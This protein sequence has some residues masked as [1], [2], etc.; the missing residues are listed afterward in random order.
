MKTRSLSSLAVLAC[1]VV[2]FVGGCLMA[3]P[4]EVT[5]AV[6]AGTNNLTQATATEWQAVAAKIDE[7]VPEV[8]LTLSDAQ[9]QAIVEFVQLNEI[10]GVQ[11][12]QDTVEQAQNDPGSIVVPDGFLELFS[13]LSELGFNEF[14]GTLQG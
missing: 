2:L 5:W 9:A 1:P 13:G 14:L 7:L 6:K 12:I 10:D 8:D 11:D 3:A 4:P